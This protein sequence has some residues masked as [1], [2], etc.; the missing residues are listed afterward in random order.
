M[1][2]T[3]RINGMYQDSYFLRK[4]G[5][6]KKKI[7]ELVEE[8]ARKLGPKTDFTPKVDLY[9]FEEGDRSI[10]TGSTESKKKE[11]VRSRTRRKDQ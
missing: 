11:L 5:P 2:R 7:L 4:Y 10:L 9:D 3:K 6:S 8:I 1:D